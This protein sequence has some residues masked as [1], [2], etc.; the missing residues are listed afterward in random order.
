VRQRVH[1]H[2][3]MT[4]VASRLIHRSSVRATAVSAMALTSG[5]LAASGD[6]SYTDS[7]PRGTLL[8][9]QAVLEHGTFALDAYPDAPS[10]YRVV[11][12]AG[13]R[14][15]AYPPGTPAAALPAVA[16]ARLAGFDMARPGDDDKVQRALAA[17]SV[18]I[19]AV[20]ASAL[21]VR[22]LR[23]PLATTLAGILVF[24]TPVMSTMGTALWST[25]LTVVVTL[26]ALLL[27]SR[28]DASGGGPVRAATLGALLG[29]AFWCRPP[30]VLLAGLVILWVFG[31]AATRAS[32]ERRSAIVSALALSAAVVVSAALLMVMSRLTYGTWLPD[33]Y[34]GGRLAA[35]DRFGTALM[36]HL[37]SPSRGLL[38]FAPAAA[39]ALVAALLSP[40]RV[41]QVPLA[42]LALVWVCLHL[43]IVSRFPY[44]WGGY[45]FGSRL[46]VDVLP[47][48]FVF[49]CAAAAA[50]CGSSRRWRVLGLIALVPAAA[51]GIWINSVQGLFN[52]ATAT[53]NAS[54]NIDRFPG[55]ALDWR[56]P[57]FL[58]TDGRLADRLRRHERWLRAPLEP[59]VE[60]TA[61]STRLEFLGWSGVEH[62]EDPAPRRPAGGTPSVRFLV[63]EGT[64]GGAERMMLTLR[65]GAERPLTGQV[66]LNGRRVADLTIRGREPEY[67]VI[68]IPR[69]LVRTVEYDVLES[70]VLEWRGTPEREE[71]PFLLWALRI[72]AGRRRAA[73]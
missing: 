2:P 64:L 45:G 19:T 1:S 26:S 69:A 52:S 59:D 11:E 47:G 54:P 20:L 15:Y 39:L 9:A 10:D 6:V 42:A 31:R 17:I 24:G 7:D 37:V 50:V 72:H 41:L 49:S 73:Y 16:I 34:I 67:Y 8:T 33:Y 70:N 22:W 23:W 66:W 44:W 60:Y 58:A 56:L 61:R 35:S 68:G 3:P 38:I 13:H 51:A 18:G 63:G 46:L 53:W 21:A 32:T 4:R 40:R 43:V 5:L 12:R 27:V 29:F 14:F 25:N 30:A 57:Q 48:V 28:C 65:V 71:T 55:Y 62:V 36:A